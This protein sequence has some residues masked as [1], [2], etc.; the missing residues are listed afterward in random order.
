MFKAV[1]ARGHAD[2][3]SGKQQDASEYFT[4][5]LDVMSRAEAASVARF[6]SG[7][8]TSS[9]FEY[10]MEYRFECQTTGQVKYKRGDDTVQ[11]MLSL[12]IPVSAAVN[13][14]E[15]ELTQERKK[16]R[17]EAAVVSP[18]DEDVKLLIPFKALLAKLL[19]PETVEMC[20]PSLGAANAP[21]T[22]TT[23]F[24][25]FPKYLVVQLQ[26]YYVND[27]W[28]QVK[29]DA[30][31]PVPESLDLSAHRGTGLREGE[32]LIPED[33][34]APAAQSADAMVADE[35]V[36]MQLVSMGFSDNG[37]RR[38][39]L[40]TGNADAEAAMS[41][42]LE[43]MDD[44]GFNDPPAAVVQPADDVDSSL[45]AT[46][47]EM[48]Y[49]D[50]QARAALRKHK[51][52]MEAAMDWIFSNMDDLETLIAEME[53]TPVHGAAVGSSSSARSECDDGSGK[54]SLMAFISHI[55]RNT[56]H[57]HYVCH[58]KRADGW[59]LFNDEKVAKLSSLPPLDYG[60]MYMYKRDD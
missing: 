6:V 17:T 9:L 29:I 38:A 21:M 42:V 22:K 55:G 31:V 52:N 57:G 43:H 30:R 13:K 59:V 51:N 45:L 27:K 47:T 28:V 4:F 25:T 50:R 15:V 11:S 5:L 36:V 58:V 49:T 10:Q 20:N 54:Y 56:D 32:Q 8:I 35:G 3:S 41:W 18:V 7:P 33:V 60:F 12:I 26:R 40:A 39:A 53:A 37:S 44:P 23:R 1:A 14:D 24:G 48:G 2:F 34:A 46:I 16:Q 19:Q